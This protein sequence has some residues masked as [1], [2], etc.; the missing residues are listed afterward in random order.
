MGLSMYFERKRTFPHNTEEKI[1][2]EISWRKFN[3][4]HNWF[5]NNVQD[6]DDNCEPHCVSIQEIEELLSILIEI[7]TANDEYKEGR[8]TQQERDSLCLDLLPPDKGFFFGNTDLDDDY[9]DDIEY[10]IKQFQR[11]ISE[12]ESGKSQFHDEYYYDSSW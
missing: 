2:Q 5:V 9:F 3:A 8:I 12:H 1:S 7:K 11:I 6:G 4:L 10:S